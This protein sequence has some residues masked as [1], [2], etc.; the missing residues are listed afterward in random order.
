MSELDW[1]YL[2]GAADAA[3][4]A[5]LDEE[6]CRDPAAAQRLAQ[7]LRLV[8]LLRERCRQ[9]PATRS[10]SRP[11]PRLG[12]APGRAAWRPLLAAALLLLALGAA[13]WAEAASTPTR[14]AADWMLLRNGQSEALKADALVAGAAELRRPGEDTRVR[15]TADAR[16]RLP[17]GGARLQ[18]E[19]GG[20]ACQVAPQQGRP[21]VVATPHG[22]VTVLGTAFQ[23]VVAGER[24]R[25]QV[26]SGVVQVAGWDGIGRRLGPNETAEWPPAPVPARILALR[27]VDAADG[28]PIPGCDPLRDGMRIDLAQLPTRQLNVQVLVEGPVAALR[29]ALDGHPPPGSRGIERNPPWMLLGNHP[30]GRINPWTPTPGRHVLEATPVAGTAETAPTGP[31][32]RIAIEVH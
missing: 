20:I 19:A 12:A 3:E 18:L 26:E 27:L 8:A 22:T 7:R 6:L 32:L 29:T 17:A 14:P 4:V 1:R 28:R 24:S 31:G 30:D 15:L 9:E 23:V 13:W 5:A 11:R 16:L 10:H 25:C 21:F 2:D